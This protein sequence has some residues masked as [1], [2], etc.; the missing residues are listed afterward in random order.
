MSDLK[1]VISNAIGYE[2]VPLSIRDR[3]EI[4]LEHRTAADRDGLVD[5]ISA[6]LEAVGVDLHTPIRLGEKSDLL[7]PVV[8]AWTA[9]NDVEE[10]EGYMHW[11]IF[12]YVL[13]PNSYARQLTQYDLSNAEAWAVVH[14]HN[15]GM[16][17]E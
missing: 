15:V 12:E 2:P 13:K 16:G 10:R 9:M 7:E 1:Q 17:F 4:R 6:A 3:P 14:S 8:G 5:R 11:A